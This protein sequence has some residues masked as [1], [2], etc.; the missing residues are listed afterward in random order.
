MITAVSEQKI[1]LLDTVPKEEYINRRCAALSLP[2]SPVVK[3]SI[4]YSYSYFLQLLD[5]KQNFSF[6]V[7][8]HHSLPQCSFLVFYHINNNVWFSTIFHRRT[9]MIKYAKSITFKVKPQEFIKKY[10][11]RAMLPGK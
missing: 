1:L 9:D 2:A 5:S 11:L 8:P 7:L 10:F 6:G 4:Y 3:A